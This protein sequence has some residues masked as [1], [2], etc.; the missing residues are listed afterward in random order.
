MA[1]GGL[2]HLH[3]HFTVARIDIVELSLA[4]LTE[5]GLDLCVE[6]FVDME[7]L[8]FSA[9]VQAQVVESGI[10]VV[11]LLLFGGIVVQKR[12]A[13]KYELSEVEVVANAALLVV[14]GGMLL[15]QSVLL[16]VAVGV[17]HSGTAVG[18]HA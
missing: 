5:V 17:H 9:D 4:T 13:Y 6:I 1:C 14:D 12:R 15:G 11:C 3:L 10:L 2:L 8:G 7:D 18:S 16:Y